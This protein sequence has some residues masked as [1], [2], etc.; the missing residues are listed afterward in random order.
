MN[1]DN[2]I[3]KKKTKGIHKHKNII[4]LG[5]GF[6]GMWTAYNLACHGHK[7]ILLEKRSVLGGISRGLKIL[8]VATVQGGEV[9]PVIKNRVVHLKTSLFQ[10]VIQ[11]DYLSLSLF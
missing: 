9:R 6:A 2:I 3:V 10:G 5:G 4:I 8:G 1:S 7:V 11:A